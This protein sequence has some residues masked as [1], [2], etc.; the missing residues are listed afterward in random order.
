MGKIYTLLSGLR[1]QGSLLRGCGKYKKKQDLLNDNME[2]FSQHNLYEYTTH[3]G[4]GSIYRTCE[5]QTISAL[6]GN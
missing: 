6:K 3:T 4:Y 1:P 5:I 2:I